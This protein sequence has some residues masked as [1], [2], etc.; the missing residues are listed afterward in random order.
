[1]KTILI[2]DDSEAFRSLTK[3][4]L[5]SESMTVLAPKLTKKDLIEAFK[6]K[7]TDILVDLHFESNDGKSFDPLAMMKDLKDVQKVSFDNVRI[8][9]ISGLNVSIET[10]SAWKKEFPMTQSV[11]ISKPVD[12]EV[13]KALLKNVATEH[14]LP[15]GSL[16]TEYKLP[17]ELKLFPLPFR[18]LSKA[19]SIQYANEHWEKLPLQIKY[20]KAKERILWIPNGTRDGY[21]G[22]LYSFPILD[23]SY[24]VQVISP[25]ATSLF[26][27]LEK[28]LNAVFLTMEGEGF[29]RGRFYRIIEVPGSDGLLELSNANH[30]LGKGELPHR[31]P[32]DGVLATRVGTWKS[33]TPEKQK[34]HY[35]I[36]YDGKAEAN[37]PTIRRWGDIIDGKPDKADFPYLELPIFKCDED[38]KKKRPPI[39]I[40]IFDRVGTSGLS[41][42]YEEVVKQLEHV[43]NKLLLDIALM[44][45]K[46]DESRFSKVKDQ[47]SAIEEKFL[48]KPNSPEMEKTLLEEAIELTG[49]KSGLLIREGLGDALEVIHAEGTAGKFYKRGVV[50]YKS[51]VWF[52][53][54]R[55]WSDDQPLYLPKFKG[56]NIQ[57]EVLKGANC[58]RLYPSNPDDLRG[59]FR[60]GIGSLVAMPIRF[61]ER[62]VGAITLQHSEPLFFTAEIVRNLEALLNRAKGF[63]KIL[64]LKSLGDQRRIWEMSVFHEVRNDLTQTKHQLESLSEIAGVVENPAYTIM[65]NRFQR[66]HDLSQ[67]FLD[68]HKEIESSRRNK[69]CDAGKSIEKVLKSYSPLMKVFGATYDVCPDLKDSDWQMP[70]NIHNEVFDRVLRVLVDNAV[71]Y[72][73]DNGRI[74]FNVKNYKTNWVLEITNYIKNETNADLVNNILSVEEK[75]ADLSLS[76]VG[77]RVSRSLVRSYGGNLTLEVVKDEAGLHKARAILTLLLAEEIELNVFR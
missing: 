10:A 46:D 4:E 27:N 29:R 54:V 22:M 13:L 60:D 26:E 15:V 34:L 62:K 32:L 41:D 43:L 70:I 76:R 57:D 63:L 19:E 37:D 45:K 1:M 7:P 5:A 47:I 65:E 28:F 58:E 77:L 50:F 51:E 59:W 42:S 68:Y 73:S 66:L 52:P 38:D 56:S 6:S 39:G 49:A 23:E 55:C 71:R 17:E 35:E 11:T 2:I 20:I 44:L 40:F 21:L 18:V 30:E 14:K 8:W 48:E 25:V 72:G 53:I 3:C 61:G 31:E 74:V 75:D 67:N 36:R 24:L 69:F 12:P 16:A 9:L 64:E 33:L